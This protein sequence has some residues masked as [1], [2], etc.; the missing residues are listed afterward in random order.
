MREVEIRQALLERLDEILPGSL[1]RWIPGGQEGDGEAE[2]K[3]K[4]RSLRMTVEVVG[5]PNLALLG[6]R[7]KV[8]VA[9]ARRRRQVPLLVAPFLNP[10]M[11]ERCK[12]RGVRYLDLSG[13]VWIETPA[14]LIEKEAPRN[15]Y[16][17]QA[18]RRSPFADRASLILRFLLSESR[19]ATLARIG[20][21][22]GLDSGYVSRIVRSA[23]DLRYA[24]VMSDGQIRLINH[25]AMLG[26]WTAVYNWRR[27]P[28]SS[29]F[30]KESSESF[31]DRLR[32][33]LSRSRKSRCALTM[34]AGN[35]RV[36]PFVAYGVWHLYVERPDLERELV[37][38]L[39]LE[40]VP[41]DA[42]NV[43][44][45]TPYYRSSVFFNARMVEGLEVVSDLQLYL[46]LRHY[47][48]RGVEASEEILTRRLR[49][50]WRS[51]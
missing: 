7:C 1:F 34:H 13:N 5:Q 43:A 38:K 47:P 31:P 28:C 46:D 15:L 51:P 48:V 44:F 33:V 11:R 2:F 23:A 26:D 29:Y 8:L 17:H 25:E 12:D 40:R 14:I 4:G 27:N 10:E 50:G 9:R 19:P 21:A 3:V 36:S 32:D 20:A 39:R 16:P 22:T 35:N 24:T 42:G 49:P 41:E 45:L 30:L 37:E 18:K 6:E